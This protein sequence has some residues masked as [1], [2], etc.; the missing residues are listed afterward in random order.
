MAL[1]TANA[2][3]LT[4]DEAFEIGE[5]ATEEPEPPPVMPILPG[6][7]PQEEPEEVPAVE[8]A[9][10]MVAANYRD[11]VIDLDALAE[12]VLAVWAESRGDA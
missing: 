7:M 2:N 8:I 3:E 4:S 11:G 1:G 5:F 12:N 9:L 10:R 6:M